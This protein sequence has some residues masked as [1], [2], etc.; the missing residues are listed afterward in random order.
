MHQLCSP[1]PFMPTA[2][3]IELTGQALKSTIAMD[4]AAFALPWCTCHQHQVQTEQVSDGSMTAAVSPLRLASDQCAR[5][6][7]GK[8]IAHGPSHG[9]H[10][11]IV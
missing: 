8:R 11:D 4:R 5:L 9:S 6:S 7:P 2:R 1:C 3:P 10:G